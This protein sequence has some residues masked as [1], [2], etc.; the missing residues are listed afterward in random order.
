VY[1]PLQQPHCLFTLVASASVEHRSSSRRGSCIRSS[2]R[3]LG[4]TCRILLSQLRCCWSAAAALLLLSCCCLVTTAAAAIAA[5]AAALLL[6]LLSSL[7]SKS[8][9][10]AVRCCCVY[11]KRSQR[12]PLAPHQCSASAPS[13][14]VRLL[15]LLLLLLLSPAAAA[16]AAACNMWI[17]NSCLSDVLHSVCRLLS[18]RLA[19]APVEGTCVLR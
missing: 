5:A 12:V 19:S 15:M 17:C 7:D 14:L 18:R 2:I 10:R 3:R 8:L 6:L 13:F 9:C 4:I 11:C 1:P 16:V